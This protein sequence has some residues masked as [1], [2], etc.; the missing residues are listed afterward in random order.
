MFTPASCASSTGSRILPTLD[1]GRDTM[2]KILTVANNK[3]GVGKTTTA[4]SLAALFADWKLR[5]A[6]IDN[7]PQGNVGVYLGWKIDENKRNLADVYS[8]LSLKKIGMGLGNNELLRHNNILFKHENLTIFPSNH[9]LAYIAEDFQKIGALTEMLQEIRN[10]YDIIIID[11]GPY[12][13]Y[14]TRSALLAADMVLIPTEAG[15]GGLAGITQIIK[16]AETINDRHWRKIIIRVFVNNFQLSEDFDVN[17]LKKLKSLLGNRLYNTY[18]PANRHLRKSKELGVPVHLLE[19]VTKAPSRGALAYRILAKNILKDI[20]PELFLES[21]PAKTAFN[22]IADT[23]K[24]PASGPRRP[25]NGKSEKISAPS[26]STALSDM[27]DE[28]SPEE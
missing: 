15:I 21:G 4:I 13:G 10:D 12:I 25:D 20:L 22:R 14:L 11:N 16:E 5:V 6:L 27:D 18:V 7:D 26:P 8:G 2:A 24:H 1:P 28:L 3:G 23:Y 9:R 17:N 19:K